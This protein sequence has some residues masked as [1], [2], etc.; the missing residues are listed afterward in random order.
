MLENFDEI[1]PIPSEPDD[2]IHN[3]V[4]NADNIIN[5]D[6]V[7]K[8]NDICRQLE[9]DKSVKMAVVIVK[10]INGADLASTALKF[11][12]KYKLGEQGIIVLFVED[13]RRIRFTTGRQLENGLLPNDLCVAIQQ[14]RM[15]PHFKKNDY[16][17]GMIAGIEAIQGIFSGKSIDEEV[18]VD[19]MTLPTTKSRLKESLPYLIMV[20]GVLP[21][22]IIA[23]LGAYY[24]NSKLYTECPKCG[25]NELMIHPISSHVS[26]LILFNE[27]CDKCDYESQPM[28]EVVRKSFFGLLSVY[29][30]KQLVANGYADDYNNLFPEL[31]E[32]S[33]SGSDGWYDSGYDGGSDGGYDGG[34]DG[35]G[36]DSGW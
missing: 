13:I 2:T 28:A 5:S 34:S 21:F 25:Q 12:N 36:G 29:T 3:A 31:R 23:F 16:S 15:V 35:G 26:D 14:T 22:V 10:S 30:Y 9:T 18:M 8:I 32:R 19:D 11:F 4:H 27:S 7:Q 1:P 20:L 17:M 33:G 24:E 6:A